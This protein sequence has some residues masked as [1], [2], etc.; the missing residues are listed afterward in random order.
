MKP[1]SFIIKEGVF[2]MEWMTPCK[3]IL[4]TSLLKKVH[5]INKPHCVKVPK[6]ILPL[7]QAVSTT[8]Y[9]HHFKEKKVYGSFLFLSKSQLKDF[10]GP[11]EHW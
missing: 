11:Q 9:I 10:Q 3:D 5:L 1:G 7:N 2:V 8:S 4:N 6:T